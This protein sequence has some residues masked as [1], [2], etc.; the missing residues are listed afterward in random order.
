M[1]RRLPLLLVLIASSLSLVS[2]QQSMLSGTITYRERIALPPSATVDV[3][4][5]DVS[6][7]GVPGLVV[8]HLEQAA[9]GQVPIPFDLPYDPARVDA[10]R[11]Y[12]VRARILDGDRVLFA[13]T[14]TTLVLTQGHA[15]RVALML[16]SV[17]DARPRAV[18]AAN[19]P[20]SAPASPAAAP[21]PRLPPLP[22]VVELRNLPATFTGTLP[23][24]DCPGIRYELT[25]YPDDSFL[26][27]RAYI[28]RPASTADDDLGSW[29][30]SSDRR[31]IVLR[32]LKPTPEYFAIRDNFTLRALDMNGQDL[33]SRGRGDLRRSSARALDVHATMRG[34]Y[35]EAG[36]AARFTE[37]LTGQSWPVA[38]EGAARDL[39]RS[40]QQPTRAGGA[41]MA[42]VDGRL[43]PGRGAD[44]TTLVVERVVDTSA[45]GTCTPRFAAAPLENTTW[46][47]AWLDGAAV[48]PAAT[49]RDQPKL[50]FNEATPTFSGSGGCNRLAGQY[51]QRGDSLMMASVGTLRA[52]PDVSAGETAFRSVLASTRSYRI[53]GRTLELYGERR[54]L[55]ARFDAR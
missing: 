1:G 15:S 22:P 18:P 35:E 10:G 37:C 48:P 8:A 20:R 33:G 40:F 27:R 49:P 55:L 51:E 45:T 53:L 21:A 9:D 19:P 43:S 50:L 14:D 25:L 36:T 11:R 39:E 44:R 32:G 13:T 4:I 24:A 30:L 31:V 17:P 29:V 38:R 3:T 16:R 28:D 12:A 23:C 47:L 41:V 26:L 5:E 34:S 2:A 7:A 6:R 52:C 42:T 46:A 54:Q